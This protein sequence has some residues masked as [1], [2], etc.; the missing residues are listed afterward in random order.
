MKKISD[1]LQPELNQILDVIWDRFLMLYPDM[2]RFNKPTIVFNNR[3]KV[4]AG[5]CLVETN[6][7]QISTKLYL[8]NRT[9]FIENTIPHE[10][11]HQVDFNINQYDWRNKR[12]PWHG[13]NWQYI[14]I[15]YGIEPNMYHSY[16]IIK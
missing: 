15:K 1:A 10:V 2:N 4:C 7:I 16:E 5:R 13:K 3:L 11:A 8:E 12:V 14:M 6:T 9:D